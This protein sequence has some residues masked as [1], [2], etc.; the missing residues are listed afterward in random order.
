MNFN[1]VILCEKKFIHFYDLLNNSNPPQKKQQN[2][3]QNDIIVNKNHKQTIVI[4][5]YCYTR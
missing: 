1:S 3:Q 5:T 4:L 2:L